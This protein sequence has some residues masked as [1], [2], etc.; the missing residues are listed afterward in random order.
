MSLRLFWLTADFEKS[1]LISSALAKRSDNYRHVLQRKKVHSIVMGALDVR[2][3][4]AVN[5]AFNILGREEESIF[6]NKCATANLSTCK[7]RFVKMQIL[8]CC[9]LGPQSNLLLTSMTNVASDAVATDKLPF[10]TC[11]RLAG[12]QIAIA[13]RASKTRRVQIFLSKLE[14]LALNGAAAY[15]ANFRHLGEIGGERPS[16]RGPDH[17]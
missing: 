13:C 14:K 15:C 4:C 2:V 1:K 12:T 9:L 7:T 5:I 3:V 17:D 6:R 11:C 16:S 10:S 8:D